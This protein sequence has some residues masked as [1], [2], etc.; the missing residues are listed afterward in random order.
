MIN[1]ENEISIKI[2][3]WRYDEIERKVVELYI[4]EKIHSVPINP[5]KIIERRGYILIPFSRIEAENRPAEVN[6]DNDA[7]SFYSPKENNYYIIYN[8]ERPL[9]RI[10]FTLMHEIGHIELG[11]KLESDLARREADYFAGYALAPSPL[12]NTLALGNYFKIKSMFWIS[13]ECAEVRYNSFCKWK[14]FGGVLY[15]DYE[16]TLLDLFYK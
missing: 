1:Y 4:K 15:K 5:F 12:I 9:P 2:P 16:E 8:D 6:D 3:K 14:E 13:N 11:H 10:R 7:F